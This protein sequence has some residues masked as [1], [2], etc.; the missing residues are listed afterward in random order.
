MIADINLLPKTNQESKLF[1]IIIAGLFIAWLVVASL[2]IY[3]YIG[4][5]QVISANADRMDRYDHTKNELQAKLA[6]VK[7]KEGKKSAIDTATMIHLIYENRIDA[8]M[9]L[10]QLNALL[11]TKGEISNIVYNN[12]EQISLVTRFADLEDASTF[13]ANLRK[14]SFVGR[15]MLNSIAKESAASSSAQTEA[16]EEGELI[17]LQKNDTYV[18]TFS[19]TL[20]KE[21]GEVAVGANNN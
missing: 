17:P 1:Q 14:L 4:D 20:N 6:S 2:L 11:A 15:A 3:F 16:T 9:I 5:R 19:I 13:L 12:S 8:G 7:A 21:K 10:D 18:S